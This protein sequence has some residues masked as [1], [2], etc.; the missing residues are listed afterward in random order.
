MGV[1][2]DRWRRLAWNKG[3]KALVAMNWRQSISGKVVLDPRLLTIANY[4]TIVSHDEVQ[5]IKMPD[6]ITATMELPDDYDYSQPH[7]YYPSS[8]IW[9]TRHYL[10]VIPGR[11]IPA[12][13][14]EHVAIEDV[15]SPVII[16]RIGPDGKPK[17]DWNKRTGAIGGR[18]RVTWED[19]MKDGGSF[20]R[21]GSSTYSGKTE[22]TLT[23]PDDKSPWTMTSQASGQAKV[24]GEYILEW[25]QVDDSEEE[26][27]IN[28]EDFPVGKDV[29]VNQR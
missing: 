14:G 10:E 13:A 3:E 8:V 9:Y 21:S 22:Y 27:A 4:E 6:A 26:V 2:G 18:V 17:Y 24:G 11:E 19:Y 15:T 12:H 5:M 28:D 16:Q 25:V 20:V 29:V 1:P 7:P 23:R